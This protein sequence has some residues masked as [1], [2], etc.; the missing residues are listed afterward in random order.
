MEEGFGQFQAPPKSHL[1]FSGQA[2]DLLGYLEEVVEYGKAQGITDTLSLVQI[3]V[4]GAPPL[5][6]KLWHFLV[7]NTPVLEQWDSFKALITLQYP[8]IKPA[9]D[10]LEHFGEFYSYLDEACHS[11]L[12]SVPALGD[13]LQQFQVLFLA[14]VRCNVL[15]MS[16]QPQLFL[17]GLPPPVKCEVS[18][19]LTHVYPLFKLDCLWPIKVIVCFTKEVIEDGVGHSPLHLASK[20]P[21]SPFE[22]PKEL[23]QNSHS[24]SISYQFDAPVEYSQSC[25]RRCSQGEV[26][27]SLKFP[28]CS[29]TLKHFPS[30]S[31]LTL[32]SSSPYQGTNA[33]SRHAMAHPLGINFRLHTHFEQASQPRFDLNTPP[34]TSQALVHPLETLPLPR[35]LFEATLML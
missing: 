7:V 17:H 6:R 2:Q 9:E 13:Y 19:R 20:S 31:E 30:T 10:V 27:S 26:H 32:S 5:T 28:P 16:H 3:A 14:M 12:S 25:S 4:D 35:K 18:R 15:E 21:S 29:P 24:P 8:E 22:S 33:G 1:E 11:E 23:S 34:S